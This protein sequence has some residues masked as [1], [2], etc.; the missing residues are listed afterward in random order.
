MSS[1][2]DE[3]NVADSQFP[4][5]EELLRPTM[6]DGAVLVDAGCV[7]H[8]LRNQLTIILGY[9]RM[10]LES[11]GEDDLARGGLEVIRKAAEQSSLLARQLMA[12]RG[13][14]KDDASPRHE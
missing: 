11:M 5:I 4:G 10:L 13:D 3:A 2:P 8:E 9:S 7:A 6:D 14:A 12:R 1:A